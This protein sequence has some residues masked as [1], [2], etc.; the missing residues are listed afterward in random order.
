MSAV[1]LY[2]GDVVKFAGDALICVFDGRAHPLPTV[3]AELKSELDFADLPPNVKVPGVT[4]NRT[5]EE[6]CVLKVTSKWIK[7]NT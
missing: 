7:S 5:T 4:T 1:T 3:A 6:A 2:G